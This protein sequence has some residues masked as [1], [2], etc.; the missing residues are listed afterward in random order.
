M[1]RFV[2]WTGMIS[3]CAGLGLQ[4]QGLAAYLMPSAEPGM[5]LHLCGLVVVFAGLTLILCSRDLEGRGAL[6]IWEGLLRVSVAVVMGVYGLFGDGGMRLATAGL[7]DLVIAAV[8]FVVLPRYLGTS[9]V[10]LLLDRQG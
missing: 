10:D 7:G 8:Y 3:V 9:F 4:F 6:V 2:F 1:K 5:V